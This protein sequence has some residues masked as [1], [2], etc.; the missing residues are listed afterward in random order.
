MRRG[1]SR[2]Y[3]VRS[4]YFKVRLESIYAHKYIN[5]ENQLY[6]NQYNQNIFKFIRIKLCGKKCYKYIII[7]Q[8]DTFYICFKI[9]C[10]WISANYVVANLTWS[11]LKIC[12]AIC[13]LNTLIIDAICISSMG[14]NLPDKPYN[15][16][17]HLRH[18]S[19]S[20]F[21]RRYFHRCYFIWCR[22]SSR[23]L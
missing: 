21:Y 20:L 16:T 11:F 17:E 2:N 10:K 4:L 18:L 6:L 14:R 23:S 9:K 12:L 8:Y 3:I 1:D 19:L 22:T 7:L 5:H 13:I 15:V